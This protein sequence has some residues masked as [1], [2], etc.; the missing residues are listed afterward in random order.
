MAEK[1]KYI[2]AATPSTVQISPNEYGKMPPQA[3]ELEE[4]VLG[5]LMIEKDAYFQVS[6]ILKPEYFYKTAHQKI[7]EAIVTLAYHQE[8]IDMHTVT[9]QLRKNGSLEEVGGPYYITLLT[10]KVSSAAHLE[11]HSRIIVQK[12]LA[13]EL[14]RISNEI[15][16]KAFDEKTDVDDLLEESEAMLFEVS[17]R[18]LKK[19]V[20]PISSV[21]DEAIQRIQAAASREGASGIPTGFHSLDKIT[22]GWQKS[23]LII[24]AARPSMGKTAFV[25]SMAKNMA[26][27]YNIPVGIFSLEMS[28]IQLANRLIMNICEIDGSKIK[29]GELEPY[30]WE[31]LDKNLKDLIDAPIYIDDTPSLSI[32]ELRSKARRLV[33][34]HYV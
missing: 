6:E 32:F 31:K 5:A 2:K 19:E 10:A 34:E 14:I 26:M 4:A 21:L 8:P 29:N 7:F 17:Q 30:E 20:L 13:R 18:N 15:Q 22:S 12:Y 3:P 24:I 9:E 27:N 1:S 16:T 33:K 28:N 25:L 11:Y 23:D